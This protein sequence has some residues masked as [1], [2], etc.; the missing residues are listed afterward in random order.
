LINRYKVTRLIS[1]FWK[2]ASVLIE[3]WL[4]LCHT[5]LTTLT[6]GNL[7]LGYVGRDIMNT[8]TCPFLNHVHT[9]MPKSLMEMQ[10][11]MLCVSQIV[12]WQVANW[13]GTVVIGWI[14]GCKATKQGKLVNAWSETTNG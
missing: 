12:R 8:M 4:F 7:T 2:D 1:I 14:H 6:E 11:L 10:Q 3:V 9:L 13:D 5:K